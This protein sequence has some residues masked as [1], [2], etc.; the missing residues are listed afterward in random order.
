[1]KPPKHILPIIVIAQ[2]FCTSLWFAGNGVL[3]SLLAEK[4]ITISVGTVTASVQFGFIIG[5]LLF[6]MLTITD[7]FSPSKVFLVCAVLGA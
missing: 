1:M 7:R 3:N 4:G 2:F 5:T 6:A